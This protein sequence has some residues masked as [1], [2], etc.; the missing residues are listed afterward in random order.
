MIT[1]CVYCQD[2][3]PAADG[4]FG[5]GFI[6]QIPI[7]LQG[8]KMLWFAN[9]YMDGMAVQLINRDVLL[10]GS[11]CRA[12]LDRMY[13]FAAAVGRNAFVTEQDYEIAAMLTDKNVSL[14]TKSVSK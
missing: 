7:V 2:V 6:I 12:R 5:L 1:K 9:G 8:H 10:T 14:P 13:L 11:F 4:E 3:S